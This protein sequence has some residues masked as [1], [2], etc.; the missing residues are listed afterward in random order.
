MRVSWPFGL[1][2]VM[3]RAEPLS[4][5]DWSSFCY[6]TFVTR[7]NPQAKV[8]FDDNNGD[9]SHLTDPIH[10]IVPSENKIDSYGYYDN[11]IVAVDYGGYR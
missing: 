3:E 9:V 1:L 11:R 10:C 7:G 5:E 4:D 8:I 2:L 6:E